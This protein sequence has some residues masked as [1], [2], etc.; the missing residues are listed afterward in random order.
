MGEES[1]WSQWW[2]DPARLFGVLGLACGLALVLLLPPYQVADEWRHFYRAYQLS[3]GHMLGEGLGDT[4]P[5]AIQRLTWET[6]HRLG[7]PMQR[8][9]PWSEMRSILAGMAEL[10]I[11]EHDLTYAPFPTVL[12]APVPYLGVTAGV[13]LGR[14]ATDRPLVLMYSGRLGGLLLAL[15]LTWYAIRVTP[16]GRWAFFLVAMTPVVSY[17]RA[18]LSADS[19][20][21]ALAMVQVALVLA[22]AAGPPGRTLSGRDLGRLGI[23]TT[24]LCLCKQAYLVLPFLGWLIPKSRFRQPADRRLV[25]LW[26]PL[27]GWTAA[28]AWSVLVMGTS[29]R[30]MLPGSDAQGQLAFIL[31]HPLAFLA[32]FG[33]DLTGK[34]L[35]YLHEL[36]GTLGWLDLPAPQELVL[37]HAGALLAA[38][39]LAATGPFRPTAAIRLWT[40]AV[41]AASVGLV[42]T[43]MYLWWAPVG[44]PNLPGMQGR[45]FTPLLPLLPPLLALPLA[46]RPAGRLW[47]LLP[48]VYG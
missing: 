9:R 10:R 3:Q 4:L 41:L 42:W 12:Y 2:R 30:P 46:S 1:G 33:R 17:Q 5:A 37:L 21:N 8:P 40:L 26:L 15:A 44:A 48:A 29:Y 31:G 18:G 32:A 20:I 34:G 25:R 39:L 14:L 24:A 47:P 35:P 43:L 23:V 19:L 36:L 7:V 38:S 6:E 28:A 27:L 13:A 45:Y 11:D 16:L 22:A